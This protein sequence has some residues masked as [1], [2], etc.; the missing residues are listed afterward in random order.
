VPVVLNMNSDTENWV[1]ETAVKPLPRFGMGSC[2]HGLISFA[3]PAS[4]RTVAFA[5]PCTGTAAVA[6]K[7]RPVLAATGQAAGP[8]VGGDQFVYMALISA[9]SGGALG[10][11]PAREPV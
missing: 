11:H 4:T 9:T 8:Q 5:R 7:Q 3:T 6:P 10:P 2:L 1:V